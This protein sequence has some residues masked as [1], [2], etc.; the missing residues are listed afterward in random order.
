MAFVKGGFTF[1]GRCFISCCSVFLKTL[2]QGLKAC[3]LWLA[4]LFVSHTA[5]AITEISA[6]KDFKPRPKGSEVVLLRYTLLECF[7][8]QK[9]AEEVLGG[10]STLIK[11]KACGDHGLGHVLRHDDVSAVA[12]EDKTI[13]QQ[14]SI[15]YI[16]HTP[17][18][19]VEKGLFHVRPAMN[20]ELMTIEDKIVISLSKIISGHIKATISASTQKV[21]MEDVTAYYKGD[22]TYVYQK[23]IR[24]TRVMTGAE[25]LKLGQEKIISGDMWVEGYEK[26]GGILPEH[27]RLWLVLRIK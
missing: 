23:P 17:E 25:T 22:Q 4:L 19:Y 16:V 27:S 24:S 9:T 15:P 10:A 7:S 12:G 20:K 13:Q 6:P 11:H 14:T 8:S 21:Q 5:L 2:P 18:V 1:L 26:Q 3:A